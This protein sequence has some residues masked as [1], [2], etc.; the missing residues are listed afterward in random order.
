MA[1]NNASEGSTI[2]QSKSNNVEQRLR[3]L[4]EEITAVKKENENLK[5]ALDQKQANRLPNV[6]RRQTLAGLLGGS[7]FLGSTG[8]V[9]AQTSHDHS[10]DDLGESEPVHSI[11]VESILNG[12]SDAKIQTAWDGLVVPVA[13]GLGA[14]AAIDPTS[15]PTPLQDAT[16]LC[17]EQG[18][19]TV[20]LPP[21]TIK[22]EDEFNPPNKVNIIGRSIDKSRIKFTTI[23]TDA[24]GFHFGGGDGS[25]R[26]IRSHY[27]LFAV[28]GPGITEDTGHAWF[29][30]QNPPPSGVSVGHLL[31]ANWSNSVYRMVG[32]ATNMTHENIR[33]SYCDAGDTRG[34][35]DL[36]GTGPAVTFNS[37]YV[38]AKD[39]KTGADSNVLY[40]SLNGDLSINQL[41]C[42]GTLNSAVIQKDNQRNLNINQINYEPDNPNT[43][44]AEVLKLEDEGVANIGAVR[45]TGDD[46]DA[47]YVYRLIDAG[48]KILGPVTG[49]GSINKNIVQIV[50]EPASA[51]WYYGP[52]S[53]VTNSA[54]SSTGLVRSLATAGTGNG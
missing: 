48:N 36:L 8:T 26:G 34:L 16:D 40:T 23:G 24:H 19:G 47:N 4:E 18:G 5:A 37:L 39:L 46:V 42:G 54:N 7:A 12:I 20:L 30:D 21:R 31:M 13:Q 35:I 6:T 10:S 41:N 44:S 17:Y 9:N 2:D 50:N 28:I 29:V 14:N 22:E 43:T 1:N 27:D 33:I 51:S 32:N 49:T 38:L 3:A 25:G 45:L 52:N 15:T 11:T 53:N